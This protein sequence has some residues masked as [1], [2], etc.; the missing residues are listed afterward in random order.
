MNED[1]TRAG[2]AEFV[3]AENA[4]STRFAYLL[5]G[6]RHHAEDLVQVALARVAV[7]WERL[8]DPGAYLRRVLYTQAASG[9]GGGGRGRR[10]SL[11]GSCRTARQAP[12]MM[13]TYEW[14]SRRRWP[15]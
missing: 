7:R 10:N 6:D 9:G 13:L 15:G 12:A 1:R 2:F 5:T 8:D 14:C 11:T 4:A 3:R